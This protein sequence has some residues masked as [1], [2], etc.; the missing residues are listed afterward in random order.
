MV[1]IVITTSASRMIVLSTAL[2]EYALT[3]PSVTPMTRVNSGTRIDINTAVRIA[4]SRR[5]K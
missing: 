3:V 4:C 1:G 2:P 5:L